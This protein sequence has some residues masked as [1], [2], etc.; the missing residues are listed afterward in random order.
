MLRDHP[1]EERN[2]TKMI[3]YLAAHGSVEVWQDVDLKGQY[4]VTFKPTE[5]AVFQG[6]RVWGD[7]VNDS[8]FEVYRMFRADMEVTA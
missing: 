1:T 8:L 7:T 4:V 6:R 2:T 5:A 3:E